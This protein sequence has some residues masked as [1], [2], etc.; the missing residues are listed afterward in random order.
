MDN[1]QKKK[2]DDG[3]LSSILI[4][5]GIFT[6]ALIIV[7]ITYGN[8][9]A[10]FDT[11]LAWPFVVGHALL[12]AGW[13]STIVFKE[14]PNFEWLRPVIIAIAIISMLIVLAHRNSWLGDKDFHSEVDKN[15]QEQLK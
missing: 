9:T 5:C 8:M 12:L 7:D 4:A 2:G 15:K 14:D 10:L 11:W 6:V 13:V 1:E 3:E